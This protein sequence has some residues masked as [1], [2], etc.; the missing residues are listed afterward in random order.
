VLERILVLLFA[1]ASPGA[2]QVTATAGLTLADRYV[3]RGVTRVNGWVL[4]P[5]AATEVALGSGTLTAALWGNVELSRAGAGDLGDVGRDRRGLGELDVELSAGV[6]AGPLAFTA[7]WI[8]YTY[9]GEAALGGRSA[10]ANTSELFGAAAW[11]GSP[12]AP[13][14]VV[15]GNVEDARGVYAELAATL[16]V[17]A[18]PEP[19]PAAIIYLQPTA[20]WAAGPGDDRGLTHVDI[21]L[22]LDL[23][24]HGAALEPSVSF[25]LHTQWN[26]DAATRVTDAIGGSKRVKLWAELVVAA[27]ALPDRRRR[28]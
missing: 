4:Q 27:V 28:R 9:H 7:G 1:L 3:W 26:R 12:L 14:V 16:P 15:Y 10:I 13:E 6:D 21:P 24:L 22:A 19:R 20:G 2:A 11:R 25:R 17:F 18:S 5:L 23:Q 8:R